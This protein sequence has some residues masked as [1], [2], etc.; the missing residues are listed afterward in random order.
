MYW[1]RKPYKGFGLAACSFDGT[2]RY[3]NYKNLGEYLE[4][5]GKKE[6][7][8]QWYEKLTEEQV[9]LEKLM[10]GLRTDQGVLREKMFEGLSK[11]K[12][13]QLED[14]IALL[15]KNKFIYENNGRFVISPNW[16]TI[17]NEIVLELLV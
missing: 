5:V 12:R 1:E 13:E 6:S 16:L 3:Q 7:G 11:D 17:E 14:K 8:C 9:R 2:H 15:K 4:R 10:L